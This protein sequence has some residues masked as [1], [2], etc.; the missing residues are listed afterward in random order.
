MS[1]WVPT[2]AACDC[3]PSFVREVR[4]PILLEI[5][6]NALEVLREADRWIVVG[7][8][9]PL[10]DLAIRSMLLRA[11]HERDN[12]RPEVVVIQKAKTEPEVSR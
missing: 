2:A 1:L 11:Y 10:E 8:S 3:G 7:Y 5:W 4:D 9:L 12:G 6:R